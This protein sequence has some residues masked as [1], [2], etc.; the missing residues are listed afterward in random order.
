MQNAKFW[1]R[2]YR[3]I[4]F[5]ILYAKVIEKKEKGYSQYAVPYYFL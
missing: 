3:D 2:I 1:S 5:N 4:S